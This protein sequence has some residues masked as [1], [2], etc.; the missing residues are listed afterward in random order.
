[1]RPT[2]IA[3]LTLAIFVARRSSASKPSGWNADSSQPKFTPVV[4]QSARPQTKTLEPRDYR[5]L[6]LAMA[7]FYL[8]AEVA[9][10]GMV[11]HR[12]GMN[13]GFNRRD[14]NSPGADVLIHRTRGLYPKP[15]EA[16]ASTVVRNVVVEEAAAAAASTKTAN[17][18]MA[19][20]A[21][22]ALM[23][24]IGVP[25]AF[26]NAKLLPKPQSKRSLHQDSSTNST[27]LNNLVPVRIVGSGEL[28]AVLV[29][30]DQ[31]IRARSSLDEVSK[32]LEI[33]SGA[34]GAMTL[35]FSIAGYQKALDNYEKQIHKP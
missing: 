25:Y 35:P 28:N 16:A 26:A 17:I 6:R 22:T 33:G 21:W 2:V 11:G 30:V 27:P 12:Y 4:E 5:T 34:I 14:S 20:T 19:L 8:T 7:G 24:V 18:N 23:S 3:F 15:E 9:G 10:L 31:G 29:P 32:V 13:Y 1:M